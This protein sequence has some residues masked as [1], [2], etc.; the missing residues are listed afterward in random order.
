[1]TGLIEWKSILKTTEP[2]LDLLSDRIIKKFS[3]RTSPIPNSKKPTWLQ[4]H[5]KE[6]V[7]RLLLFVER[8]LV[9]TLA[10]NFATIFAT[11]GPPLPHP[12]RDY[13]CVYAG[14]YLHED[15]SEM[16]VRDVIRLANVLCRPSITMA[17]LE[18]YGQFMG[19]GT[20]KG[21]KMFGDAWKQI[22]KERDLWENVEEFGEEQ[23]CDVEAQE[24]ESDYESDFESDAEDAA[25]IAVEPSPQRSQASQLA[26]PNESEGIPTPALLRQ[27]KFSVPFPQSVV[28]VGYSVRPRTRFSNHKSCRSLRKI[29][30]TDRPKCS[31]ERPPFFEPCV[32]LFNI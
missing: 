29:E 7:K 30:L 1:M 6:H 26:K 11:D 14:T 28:Y 20:A 2:E 8:D 4:A 10:N 15:G 27:K 13:P 12:K 21:A 19:P 22:L 23:D 31:S 32:K 17:I 3:T 18:S 24:N 9:P 16:S 25:M 5:R